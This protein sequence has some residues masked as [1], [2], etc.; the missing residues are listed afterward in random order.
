MEKEKASAA[1]GKKKHLWKRMKLVKA[2]KKTSA[3]SR[4]CRG[5][6]GGI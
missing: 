1:G 5:E 3:L 6:D 4:M 2:I